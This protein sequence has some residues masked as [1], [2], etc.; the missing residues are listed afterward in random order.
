M[1]RDA[2]RF[3]LAPHPGDGD[4]AAPAFLHFGFAIEDQIRIIEYD[5]EPGLVSFTCLDPDGRR[6]EVGRER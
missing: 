1:V 4:L 5:E 6:A 2:E 3:D